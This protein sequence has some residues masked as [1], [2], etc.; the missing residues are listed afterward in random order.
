MHKAIR[1]NHVQFEIRGSAYS[2]RK[3]ARLTSAAGQGNKTL[4]LKLDA[5]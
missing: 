2:T 3:A 4:G 5:V 1:L